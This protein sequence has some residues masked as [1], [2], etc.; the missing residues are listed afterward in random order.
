MTAPL[1]DEGAPGKQVVA[2]P[3]TEIP[4]GTT[5]EGDPRAGVKGPCWVPG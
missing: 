5:G 3:H 1:V 4:E 2:Q